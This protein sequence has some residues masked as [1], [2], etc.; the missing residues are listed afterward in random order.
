MHKVMKDEIGT[1]KE[2]GQLQNDGQNWGH[3]LQILI[4]QNNAK[5]PTKKGGHVGHTP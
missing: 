1:H 4:P 2:V 5:L 3:L